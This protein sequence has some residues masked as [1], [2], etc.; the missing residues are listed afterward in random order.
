MPYPE[1]KWVGAF[2]SYTATEVFDAQVPID[3]RDPGSVIAPAAVGSDGSFVAYEF[4]AANGFR[5]SLEPASWLFLENKRPDDL[6]LLTS[7]TYVAGSYLATTD[8][9]QTPTFVGGFSTT[10]TA[11]FATDVEFT[12]DAY[13]PIPTALAFDG[14]RASVFTSRRTATTCDYLTSKA[15]TGSAD[16]IPAMASQLA[17]SGFIITAFGQLD[18]VPTYGMIGVS[19]E[20]PRDVVVA[21]S[22]PGT[23][24][25]SAIELFAEG[26]VP[27]GG[28][29]SNGAPYFI[30]EK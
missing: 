5:P 1:F 30:F 26:Y 13:A 7:L 11:T 28:Y 14:S 2:P 24:S 19:T 18:A 9:P 8:N 21:Q 29:V 6:G 12:A 3:G 23:G 4:E 10:S 16:D 20:T 17:G 27:V 22:F 25:G 15:L